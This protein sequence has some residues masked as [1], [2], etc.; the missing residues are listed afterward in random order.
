MLPRRAPDPTSRTLP[1]PGRLCQCVRRARPGHRA[2]REG[3]AGLHAATYAC[4]H[5]CIATWQL[6][7]HG[8]Q[9]AATAMQAP[10]APAACAWPP[11]TPF[12]HTQSPQVAIKISVDRYTARSFA[13]P[14]D[15]ADYRWQKR[16]RAK[17]EEEYEV[18]RVAVRPC[19]H[20]VVHACCCLRR[21]RALSAAL[22]ECMQQGLTVRN[23][24]PAP[25]GL[26]APGSHRA[27]PPRRRGARARRADR[28]RRGYA[29]S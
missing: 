27:G 15:A 14:R 24:T 12:M 2:R 18:W 3:A 5:A 4:M 9:V 6:A 26:P 25:P 21:M 13:H 1:I 16:V 10:P 29:L 8:M 19:M 23:V 11:T 17:C 20:A 7:V 22:H 28:L